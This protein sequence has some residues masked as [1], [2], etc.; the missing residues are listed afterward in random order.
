MKLRSLSEV[1]ISELLLWGGIVAVVCGLFWLVGQLVYFNKSEGN[2]VITLY[3]EDA[4]RRIVTGG[5]DI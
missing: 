3:F 1:I 2:Q 5:T 4:I